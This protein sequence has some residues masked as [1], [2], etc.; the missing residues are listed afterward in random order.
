MN[1]FLFWLLLVG[2][3]IF[4]GLRLWWIYRRGIGQLFW[5]T[6]RARLYYIAAAAALI[7]ALVAVVLSLQYWLLLLAIPGIYILLTFTAVKVDERAIIANAVFARWQDI[8]RLQFDDSGEVVTVATRYAW[9]R[10][11]LHVPPDKLGEF[12]KML[13]AKGMAMNAASPNRAQEPMAS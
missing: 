3:T 11:K 10:I 4:V 5:Q 6:P 2:M 8:S 13:A 1:N 12:K 7:I 9:R